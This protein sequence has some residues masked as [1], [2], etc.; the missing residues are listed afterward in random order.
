MPLPLSFN[1][2]DRSLSLSL[3]LSS[4]FSFRLSKDDGK[5]A[6][7]ND[8]LDN[9]GKYW[10][11]LATHA[12]E[13]TPPKTNLLIAVTLI[14][15]AFSLVNYL[16]LSFTYNSTIQRMRETPEFKR[17]VSRLV[18]SKQAKNTEEAEDMIELDVVGLEEPRW[19]NLVVVK[20][21]RSPERFAK[22]LKWLALWQLN[23]KILKKEMTL[24]DKIY[25]IQQ[26]IS[27]TPLE[28]ERLPESTQKSLLE[29]ELWKTEEAKEYRRKERIALNK[30]GKLKKMKKQAAKAS[31][32]SDVQEDLIE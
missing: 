6:K 31:E 13:V 2:A 25:M 29:K 16:N 27:M 14:I 8:F 15:G 21:V 4:D 28:Y 5:R 24:E 19:E 11:F 17:E 20:F 32:T 9:P 22:Y 26:N 12:K 7:Y 23:Y 1:F 18:K 30:T 3:R 10:D